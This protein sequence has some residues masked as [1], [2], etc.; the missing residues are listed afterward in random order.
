MRI[1]VEVRG[2]P[3][4]KDGANSM[5]RKAAEIP[6]LK[7]LRTAVLERLGNV[8][9][10]HAFVALTLRVYASPGA[11]DLDNFITGICDGL[12]SAHPN[13]IDY[14]DPVL[15]SDVPEGARPD[16]DVV[17]SCDSCV[18]RITAERFAPD[19]TEYYVLEVELGE[20]G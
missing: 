3:P 2:L 18:W 5:W 6:R 9:T 20:V 19:G 13:I 15:W 11:G 1:V 8:S 4:K 14:I 16:K 12:M 10:R 7:A 17:Y